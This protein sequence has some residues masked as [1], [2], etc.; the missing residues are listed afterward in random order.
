MRFFVQGEGK[1]QATVVPCGDPG[2]LVEGLK[3]AILERL[4]REGDGPSDHYTLSLAGS[5]ATISDKDVIQE[6][7]RDGDFL[8]LKSEP[9]L[10]R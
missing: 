7:L 1:S 9:T 10:V 6:V 4:R 2:G 3:K 8:V 5:G